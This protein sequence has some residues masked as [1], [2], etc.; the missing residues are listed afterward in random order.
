MRDNT[1]NKAQALKTNINIC[2][3]C[4]VTEHDIDLHLSGS[5]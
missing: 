1:L 3:Y 4:E 5:D 2:S